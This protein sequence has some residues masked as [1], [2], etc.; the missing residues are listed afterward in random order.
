[1]MYRVIIFTTI[2]NIISQFC[3][4]IYEKKNVFIYNLDYIFLNL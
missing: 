3:D 2:T 1:M 4:I